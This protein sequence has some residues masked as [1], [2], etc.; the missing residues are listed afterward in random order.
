MGSS[1][2]CNLLFLGEIFEMGIPWQDTFL[3]EEAEA[4]CCEFGEEEEALKCQYLNS[5]EA[6]GEY[7]DPHA[8]GLR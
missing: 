8:R 2:V 4:G 3:A 6:S 5:W 7:A 1:H